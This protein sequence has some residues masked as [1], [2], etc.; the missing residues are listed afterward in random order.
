MLLDGALVNASISTNIPVT[1]K[2]QRFF[3]PPGCFPNYQ[4]PHKF[5]TSL[6]HEARYSVPLLPALIS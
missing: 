4:T 5:S 3:D 6:G 1:G 2:P